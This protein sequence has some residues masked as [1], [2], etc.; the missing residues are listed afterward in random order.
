MS[1]ADSKHFLLLLPIAVFLF[2]TLPFWGQAPPLDAMVI[3]KQSTLFSVG[4]LPEIFATGAHIHPPLIFILNHIGF[5]L[6]G[7]TVVAYNVVGAAI[8][9][10]SY[11]VYYRLI[12]SLFNQTTALICSV[13]LFLQPQIIINSLFLSNDMLIFALT[14][15]ASWAFI[16]KRYWL[17]VLI[18]TMFALLKETALIVVAAYFGILTHQALIAP[19]AIKNKVIRLLSLG[20]WL[21]PTVVLVYLWD[22]IVTSNESTRWRESV[23]SESE[24]GSFRVVIN[25]FFSLWFTSVYF[26]RNVFNAF[27][28]NFQ[29]VQTAL[30]IALAL[31]QRKSKIFATPS[32]QLLKTTFAVIGAVYV[33]F[34]LAFPTWT[35][36]RYALPIFLITGTFL[37]ILISHIKNKTIR[38]GLCAFILMQTTLSFFVSLDPITKLFGTYTVENEK[39]Y[40]LNDSI[41]GADSLFYNLQIAQA[42]EKQ[43]AQ[44][45]SA[46]TN[47]TDVFAVDCYELKL[48]ERIEAIQTYNE[49]YPQLQINK[50]LKCV[51]GSELY[52]Y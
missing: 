33:V 41:G 42:T 45:L 19:I 52:P 46:I 18:A 36:P 49:F 25:T 40:A 8:Y 7:K 30:L 12:K 15:F 14:I 23:F 28:F 10:L 34:V 13:L 11:G 39:M 5:L 37:G 47:Q 24:G 27:V 3:Y 50:Q 44:I 6:F 38:L 51:D 1:K 29:W 22:T 20:L 43:N 17:F 16:H 48:S 21:L 26:L 2:A 32:Q 31:I 9:L 4:G 35:I